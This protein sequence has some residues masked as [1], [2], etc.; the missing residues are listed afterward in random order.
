MPRTSGNRA[1]ERAAEEKTA[2]A[3]PTRTARHQEPGIASR[4]ANLRGDCGGLVWGMKTRSGGL[5]L[6]GRYMFG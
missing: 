5:G 3:S 1:L 4:F 2:D 6:S